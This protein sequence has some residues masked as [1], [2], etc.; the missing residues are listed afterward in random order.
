MD[1]PM[2]LKTLRSF[3]AVVETQSF[4]KAAVSL[5]LTQSALTRQIQKLEADIG[6]ELLTRSRRGVDLTERGALLLERARAVLT[7]VEQIR[8]LLRSDSAGPAG[9]MTLGMSPA[10]GQMLIPLLLERVARLYPKI[11]IHVVEAFTAQIH[12]GLL[13]RRLDLG[14]LHDPEDR[15]RLQVEPLLIEPLLLV[16]PRGSKPRRHHSASKHG[17][18]MLAELPL[19]L[20]SRPNTLRVHIER[21]VGAAGLRLNVRA[22]VDSI[23]ITKT[24]VQ[25]GYGYTVL[26]YE[27][28]HQEIERGDL[29]VVPIRHG[30]FNRRVVIARP[31]PRGETV[32]QR[33]VATL[34]RDIGRELIEQRQWPGARLVA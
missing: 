18:G 22:E 11:R 21:I 4:T 14:V 24:L 26:S 5:N 30:S 6:A 27:L 33:C 23:S 12:E 32:L 17:V 1:R 15:K 19:I 31:L 16:G 2:D 9:H 25:R 34:I 20:P 10:A 8:A 3:V 28:L 29:E 13:E 7:E